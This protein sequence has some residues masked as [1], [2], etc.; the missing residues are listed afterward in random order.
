[1]LEDAKKVCFPMRSLSGYTQN[2]LDAADWLSMC[3][4]SGKEL[5]VGCCAVLAGVLGLKTWQLKSARRR[6]LHAV[7]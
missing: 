2:V 6:T 5:Q 1:M 3:L 7:T 4:F